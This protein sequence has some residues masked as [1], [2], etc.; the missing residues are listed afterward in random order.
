DADPYR[1]AVRD[2]V[3]AK[4]PSK[5]AELAGQPTALEQPAGFVAFLGEVPVIPLERRRHLLATALRRRPRDLGLLMTL[6]G[7]YPLSQEEGA[8]AGL[9]WYQAAV[10]AAPGNVVAHNGLGV[11]L[12]DK[13][14][15]AGAEAAFREA[16]ALDPKFAM[17]H[18][19]LGVVL[20][21]KGQLDEAIACW[22]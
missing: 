3:L 15:P 5:M 8:N 16:I 18:N 10:A 2:V 17:A 12:R 14:D 9:R 1:D 7:A 21:G 13:K 11:A 22:K 19:N 4:A 20:Q 6:G